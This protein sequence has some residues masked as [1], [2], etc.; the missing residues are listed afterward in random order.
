MEE[1][2]TRWWCVGDRGGHTQ[3]PTDN[4]VWA[5]GRGGGLMFGETGRFDSVR[6]LTV[7][8]NSAKS[9]LKHR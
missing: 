3:A 9:R 1:K 7:S 4:T 5:A 6:T 8:V 2:G